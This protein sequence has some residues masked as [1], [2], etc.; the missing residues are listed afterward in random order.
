M[1]YIVFLTLNKES[2]KGYIGVTEK[3]DKFDGYINSRRE[4]KQ[5]SLK[6]DYLLILA[7]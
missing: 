3:T 5:C 2:N 7:R 1:A 6:I 4:K